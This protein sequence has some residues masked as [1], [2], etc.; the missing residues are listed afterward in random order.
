MK[1]QRQPALD[2]FRVPVVDMAKPLFDGSTYDEGRD[3]ARLVLQVARV[4][5]ALEKADWITLRQLSEQTG[6]PEASVSARLRDLRKIR[7]GSH[8]IDRHYVS[9][10]VFQYRLH[11][12]QR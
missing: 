5:A 7:W 4:K 3:E 1:P 6:A 2:L 11:K 8:R 10:G 9:K 12:E